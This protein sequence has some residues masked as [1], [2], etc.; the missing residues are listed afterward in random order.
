MFSFVTKFIRFS[1]FLLRK[2][3]RGLIMRIMIV[4]NSKFM[5]TFIRNTVTDCGWDVVGEASDGSEAVQLYAKCNP[6]VV[7]MDI[8]MVRM[9]GV[10]AVR[11]LIAKFP[12]AIVVMVSAIE[13][14]VAMVQAIQAG[15][16]GYVAKPF[17][18]Y[19][20]NQEIRRVSRGRKSD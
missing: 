13:Q 10:E 17:K 5:R 1:S 18:S 12:S 19:E 11:A 6:D 8:T 4:D 9:N 16:V 2:Y 14:Q 20:L 7:T 3:Q 15:A